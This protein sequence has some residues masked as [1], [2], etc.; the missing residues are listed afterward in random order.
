[1]HQEATA[2][3]SRILANYLKKKLQMTSQKRAR[4]TS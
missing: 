4:E 2:G 3:S 1:M